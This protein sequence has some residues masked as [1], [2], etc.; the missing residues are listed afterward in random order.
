MNAM[1]PPV[2][3]FVLLLFTATF[4]AVGW[5]IA[6][7]SSK[8]YRFFTFGLMPVPEQGFYIGFLRLMGWCSAVFFGAGALA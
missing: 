8:A 3:H 2:Q 7:N 4:S 5:F 1:H 6:H